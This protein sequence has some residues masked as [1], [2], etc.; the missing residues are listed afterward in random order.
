MGD[1]PPVKTFLGARATE[2][3]KAQSAEIATYLQRGEISL[4]GR[5]D[6]VAATWL[7]RLAGKRDAQVA[8][9]SFDLEG[10]QVARTR[11]V[12]FASEGLPQVFAVGSDW[13]LTWF[14][15]GGLAYARPHVEPLPAPDIGH[16]G[17]VGPELAND[18][19]V[20]SA[21]GAL[22]AAAPFRPAQGQLGLFLFA[23]LEAGAPAAKA[24]GVTHFAKE[25]HHAAVAADPKGIFVVWH[26]PDGRLAASRFDNKGKEGESA[27]T[28]APASS[29]SREALSLVVTSSG[30]LVM[31]SEAGSV[32][33][34]AIDGS[35]CPTSP[36][37]TI[38]EG[39]W[40]A[41]A[42]HP[43]GAVVTWVGSDGRLLAA[44]VD[45][46][47]TPPAKGVDVAE[48]STGVKDPPA[49]ATMGGKVAFAW[50]EMMSATM[51]SKR[52]ALRIVDDAC[53]P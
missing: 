4:W 49:V 12:G 38:A 29:A 26:E 13:T 3:C 46:K 30:A 17:A 35:A 20:S 24:L 9:A 14:D 36:I 53:F 6:G 52:L 11:G 51:S 10:R 48:G 25:P 43:S 44:K 2:A 32:R 19:A 16:L 28:I 23:P 31:W 45:S 42:P 1:A 21:P 34:R 39:Q 8:F 5:A 47:G 37:W 40:P 7:V 18:V 27:C 50:A 22:V 15:E 33:I 41:I